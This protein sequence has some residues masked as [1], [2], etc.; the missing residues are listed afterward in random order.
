MAEISKVRFNETDYDIK[1][2]VDITLSTAGTP[3]DAGAIHAVINQIGEKTVNLCTVPTGR[4]YHQSGEIVPSTDKWVS[5]SAPVPCEPNQAYVFS[6]FDNGVTTT[7]KLYAIWF[8]SSKNTIKTDSI[9]RAGTTIHYSWTSPEN[10]AYMYISVYNSTAISA[11]TKLQITKGSTN[12]TSYSAPYSGLDS[13]ARSGIEALNNE[14]ETVNSISLQRFGTTINTAYATANNITSLLDLEKNYIYACHAN[15]TISDIPTGLLGKPF[16]FIYAASL[17]SQNYASCFAVGRDSVYAAILYTGETSI[18]WTLLNDGSDRTMSLRWGKTGSIVLL[19]DSIV[20]GVGS[21]D[22][23]STGDTI[24]TIDGTEYKRNVGVN[25][26]G[27]K[28]KAHIESD[29]YGLSVVN[30]GLPGQGIPLITNNIDAL[31]PGGAIAAIVCAGVNNRNAGASTIQGYYEALFDALKTK[32]V[33]IFALSPI[34]TNG[35]TGNTSLALINIAL[36]RACKT[37][38]VNYFNLYGAF[39]AVTSAN[40]KGDYYNGTLHPNDKGYKTM[41][42]IICNLLNL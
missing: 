26:W 5:A 21:S 25:S 18:V 38:G 6:A 24:A 37:K 2:I 9:N 41:Y 36:E 29:Y 15:L 27:A 42:G 32:G 3:A 8:D 35:A 23:S 1:S 31:V 13:T 19:G 12:P 40:T 39:N 10:A 17:S 7:S 28:F 22:Y 33:D 4:Y 30:N 34:D 14:L 16:T 20:Q 11:D